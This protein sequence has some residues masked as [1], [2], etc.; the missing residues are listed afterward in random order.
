MDFFSGSAQA[1]EHLVAA[2]N[3]LVFERQE[4]RASGAHSTVL[5]RNRREI[6]RRQSEL[7]VALVERYL[8]SPRTVSPAG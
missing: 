4:L 6:V 1:V 7:S 5:E 8:G 3:A 2:I